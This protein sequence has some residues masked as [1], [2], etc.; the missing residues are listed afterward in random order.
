MWMGIWRP[1]SLI[2]LCPE[3]CIFHSLHNPS[4][5]S[6]DYSPTW[7]I[8]CWDN[9]ILCFL[10]GGLA[11]S[12]QFFSLSDPYMSLIFFF[13]PAFP[14]GWKTG[15]WPG[16][17]LLGTTLTF[18]LSVPALSTQW[19]S[20]VRDRQQ[21]IILAVA[22]RGLCCGPE[23]PC[24]FTKCKVHIWYRCLLL[25][26]FGSH[27]QRRHY[28]VT[29]SQSSRYIISSAC[30]IRNVFLTPSLAPIL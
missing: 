3:W 28:Y 18:P 19:L 7:W 6:K 2:P 5:V 15:T 25:I 24:L 12:V 16:V 22:Q 4:L 21:W 13:F 26:L 10:L 11:S 9:D 1:V 30:S 23:A 29:G 17:C 14:L 27:W 20:L 8:I